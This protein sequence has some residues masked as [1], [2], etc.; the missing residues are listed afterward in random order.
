MRE[1]R[2]KND[3]V[4]GQLSRAL[5]ERERGNSW[6]AD[7]LLSRNHRTALRNWYV[8]QKKEVEEETEPCLSPIPP[9]HRKTIAVLSF[10]FFSFLLFYRKRA[11]EAKNVIV[12]ACCLLTAWFVAG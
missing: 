4:S 5:M 11:S 9:F 3:D 10:T 8:R 6:R 1:R 12:H 7:P 2:A